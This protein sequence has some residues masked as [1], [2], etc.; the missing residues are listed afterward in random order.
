V[1]ADP[2]NERAMND[3][4]PMYRWR[5]MSLEQRQEAL[6]FRQ[7]QRLPW[8]GPPH[9]ESETGLYLISAACYEHKPVVGA[10]PK[11]MAEFEA[12][13][14][15]VA[16]STC[17]RV[18]AWIVLPN[19]YHLL[20]QCPKVKS[21]LSALGRLHGRTSFRWNGEDNCR[22]RHVWHRAAETAM[23]SDRHFW[24]TLNYILNNAVRH[25]Y[26]ERWQDWPYSSAA[27]YLAEVGRDEAERRWRDY[28]ILD[29]GKDWD[30]PE[31]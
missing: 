4:R 17:T 26:V 8:H 14:L 7:R 25:G 12:D 5:R 2:A 28:P 23:K 22:G 3:D 15:A 10:S 30:P 29:F 16:G 19:H 11:R 20:V 1:L 21:L 18:F 13:L 24:A 9:Y 27:Q 6:A 31:L